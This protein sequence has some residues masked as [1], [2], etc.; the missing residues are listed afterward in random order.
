MVHIQFFEYIPSFLFLQGD[1]LI[2]LKKSQP[3]QFKQ[4]GG[5]IFLQHQNKDSF[6]YY[7]LP[8]LEGT[9]K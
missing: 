6:F 8:L 9:S 5:G 2:A 7:K 4:E 1:F 3:F